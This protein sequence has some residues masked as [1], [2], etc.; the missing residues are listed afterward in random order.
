MRIVDCFRSA[1]LQSARDGQ[2]AGIIESLC[3]NQYAHGKLRC[4]IHSLAIHDCRLTG[5]VE[6]CR[7][8]RMVQQLLIIPRAGNVRVE[9]DD[10]NN[11]TDEVVEPLRMHTIDGA[12]GA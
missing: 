2:G 3:N 9:S 5:L 1:L 11:R 10:G 7:E 8:L 4:L 6:P 12:F